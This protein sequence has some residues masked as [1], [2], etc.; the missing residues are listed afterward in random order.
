MY[1][2]CGNDVHNAEKKNKRTEIVDSQKIFKEVQNGCNGQNDGIYD[3]QN[4]AQYAKD[5]GEDDE[6]HEA[7]R[8]GEYDG[9]DASND[10]EQLF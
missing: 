7:G 9:H 1:Y 8:H 5:D 2:C 4:D 10:G 3:A 6:R